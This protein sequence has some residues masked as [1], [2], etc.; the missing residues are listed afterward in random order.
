MFKKL[1][2]TVTLLLAVTSQ[3]LL[4]SDLFKTIPEDADFVLQ[5]NV[6]KILSMPDVQKQINEGFANQPEQKKTYE[7]LKAKSGFDPLKDI[8]SFVLFSSGSVAEGKEPLAGAVIQGNFNVEKIVK[9]IKEDEAAAKEVDVTKVDGFNAIVPKN[10]Q[11]GYGLFLD[12]KFVTVGSQLGVDAVKA[13]KL[14]KGKSVVTKKDFNSV[15]SKL[16]G[17]SAVSG[18]GLLPEAFKQKCKQNPNAAALANL[19]YFHF[20]FNNDANLVFNLNAE[21][22]KKENVES[23][24]TQINGYVAM[25]KMFASQSPE[26]AEI[27]NMLSV[28]NA[29]TTVKLN[30]NVPAEK[31]KEIKAKL[32]KKAK[33][34]QN[35]NGVN[36][37]RN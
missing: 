3:S 30:L 7:E 11:D 20:D 21:I 1:M 6:S 9:V 15:L 12:N 18:A 22:D 5:L 36:A 35:D 37:P 19:N 25:L 2:L 16:N 4:A 28:S 24:M 32:E 33:E 31:L 34:L 14:G 8:Q 23:V 13:V 27:M 10:N 17:K 29:G 26:A